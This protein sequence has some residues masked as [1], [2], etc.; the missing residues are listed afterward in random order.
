M[1][2]ILFFYIVV[3]I[4]S[5]SP[6]YSADN[7]VPN[8]AGKRP[9]LFIIE[10]SRGERKL[11][12]IMDVIKENIG[13]LKNECRLN[14]TNNTVNQKRIIIKLTINGSGK[15]ISCTPLSFA[16]NNETVFHS[17]INDSI[18]IQCVIDKVKQLDFG[19]IDAPDGD[20]TEILYPFLFSL[21]E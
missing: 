11:N 7:V 4:L 17:T 18:F 10:T 19:A 16:D 15:V 2:R 3:I 8:R 5:N 6:L 20:T 12:N 1:S 14:T 21:Q 13:S 9:T